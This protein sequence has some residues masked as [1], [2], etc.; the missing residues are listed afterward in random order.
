MSFYNQII[1]VYKYPEGAPISTMTKT[2][3]VSSSLDKTG[4]D[5]QMM[6]DKI[7]QV[8]FLLTKGK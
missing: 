3:T 1:S 2:D 8:L 4:D 6:R 5:T 7:L